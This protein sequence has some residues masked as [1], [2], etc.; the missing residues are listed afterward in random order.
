[1]IAV[2][3][4]KRR[5]SRRVLRSIVDGELN[6]WQPFFPILLIISDVST[7]NLF[8]CTAGSF[9][10]TVSQR[11]EGGRHLEFRA[12]PRHE[13]FPKGRSEEL[14]AIGNEIFWNTVQ[15]N[16]LKEEHSQLI[17]SHCRFTPKEMNHLGE[18]INND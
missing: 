16:Y 17:R 7:K 1:M 10:L 9:S 18:S 12:Q 3:D 14:V 4:K 13:M 8:E 2:V 11:M 6:K 15:F 5:T